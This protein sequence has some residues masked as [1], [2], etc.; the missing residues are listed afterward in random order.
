MYIYTVKHSKGKKIM[1]RTVFSIEGA[2]Y[3]MAFGKPTVKQN[4][5][6]NV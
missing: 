2:R 4:S 5:R 1:T 3:W 6:A